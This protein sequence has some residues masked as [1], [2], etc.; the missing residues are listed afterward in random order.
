MTASTDFE[1]LV[2]SWL[3]TAGPTDVR[4]DVVDHALAAARGRGQRRGVQAWLVGSA[5]WPATRRGVGFSALPPTVRIA[6]LLGL[7]VAAMAAGAYVGSRLTTFMPPPPPPL[8]GEVPSA[9]E[10]GAAG[11][12][13]FG[14]GPCLTVI[15]AATVR[16]TETCEPHSYEVPGGGTASGAWN[17]AP[18][19]RYGIAVGAGG[20]DL[21]DVATGTAAPLAGSASET[22]SPD[23]QTSF[24]TWSPLGDRI[25]W[26]GQSSVTGRWD[27]FLGT[28]DDP[29]RA[30]LPSPGDGSVWMTFEWSADERRAVF[31]TD[32]NR[33]RLF[34][35]DGVAL[36]GA[37]E[38][39]DS[40]LAAISSDGSRLAFLAPRG[41]ATGQPTVDVAVTDGFAP[42]ANITSF[43]DGT[44]AVAAAWA[45]DDSILAV[46]TAGPAAQ[47]SPEYELWLV[48]PASATR[49]VPL[50]VPATSIPRSI[51]WSAE[52]THV[53]VRSQEPAPS[54]REYVTIVSIA[55]G[56]AAVSGATNAV[57]SPDGKFALYDLAREGERPGLMMAELATGRIGLVA[58][59]SLSSAGSLA[60]LE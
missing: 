27:V 23:A 25:V 58:P 6:I 2:S 17:W 30:V 35:G 31:R 50:P 1:R 28:L 49:R 48:G 45:L 18:G 52:R 22:S 47:T 46:A 15:D 7:L 5:S 40:A 39:D 55:D 16:R 60:W 57:F 38:F 19:G 11:T 32:E 13:S 3:E 33:V 51:S 20:L 10:L 54:Y 56:S 59:G 29:R 53:M 41:G 12:I 44:Y 36:R 9:A 42:L 34:A 4:A 21:F 14:A 43:P 24:V 8:R 37:V 26:V